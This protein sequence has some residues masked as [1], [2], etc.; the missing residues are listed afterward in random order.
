LYCKCLQ[1]NA[2]KQS[3]LLN[4]SSLN[5]YSRRYFQFNKEFLSKCFRKCD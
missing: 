3:S 4:I 2:F 5:I 1:I